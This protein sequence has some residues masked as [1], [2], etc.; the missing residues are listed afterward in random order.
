[1]SVKSQIIQEY[2]EEIKKETPQTQIDISHPFNMKTFWK[3]INEY[4]FSNKY[5]LNP[6]EI[7]HLISLF[8]QHCK[9]L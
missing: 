8:S 1:M 3:N 2:E 4:Q 7:S 6:Y 9:W 5:K